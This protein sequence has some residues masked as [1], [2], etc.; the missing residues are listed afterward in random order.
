MGQ[1]SR[2]WFGH[3]FVSVTLSIGVV[4]AGLLVMPTSAQAA[5]TVAVPTAIAKILADTNALRAAGGLAPLVEN[6]AMDAVAQ[7]W[8]LQM[9]TAGALTHNPG[10]STQIPAG[11]TSAGENIASGYSY[12]TVVAAWH[13]SAGHYANIMGGYTDIGIGYYELNGQ[14]YF[15]QDFGKYAA[16]VT[17]PP[18]PAPPSPPLAA[19]T[20]TPAPTRSPAAVASAPVVVAAAPAPVVAPAPAAVAAPAPVARTLMRCVQWSH[21]QCT[22][23]VAEKPHV[24]KHRVHRHTVRQL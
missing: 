5:T 6:S 4:A 7:S 17:V 19:P 1:K 14:T 13:A 2:T 3:R 16:H 18:P 9:Y 8:S 12:D 10:Y 21:H 22:R 11:W 24:V 23:S 20:L 15:T